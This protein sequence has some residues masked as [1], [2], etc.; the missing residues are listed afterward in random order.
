MSQR[1]DQP[2][3]SP[4]VH[5]R[6]G[7]IVF[8]ALILAGHVMVL[9]STH[10]QTPSTLLQRLRQMLGIQR[11]ISVGGSRASLPGPAGDGSAFN[12][13]LGSPLPPAASLPTAVQFSPPASGLSA[14]QAPPAPV[15]TAQAALP[16]TFR[17]PAGTPPREYKIGWASAQGILS[18]L[19]NGLVNGSAVCLLSPWLQQPGPSAS[20]LAHPPAAVTPSGAPP[21][22]SREP[23]GEVQIV[24]GSTLLWQGRGTA[25]TPLANLLAW[26]LSPLRPG[27]SVR[28]RLRRFGAG[29]SSF[30]EVELQ[31]P[32]QDSPAAAKMAGTPSLESLQT[33]LAQDRSAE[34]IE[35]LFQGA[36]TGVSD[37]R[38]LSSS[39][40]T[41]G[42][43]SLS[44]AAPFTSR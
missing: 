20:P 7:H 33:L 17:R 19:V 28:L 35:L 29:E 25:T 30:A 38:D 34:A 39:A 37:L 32:E 21:I 4:R 18:P 13:A 1:H 23:L 26:P 41:S 12:A 31:R 2:R 15:V 24:Q 42:C 8:M 44:T 43:T 14:Q 5:R 11:P 27:E 22:V 16:P 36:L 10:A 3:L 6:A 9:P 40:M